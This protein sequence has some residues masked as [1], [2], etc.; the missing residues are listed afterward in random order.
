MTAN[1][2][3]VVRRGHSTRVGGG[4]SDPGSAYI[5]MTVL[6]AVEWLSRKTGTSD[7]KCGGGGGVDKATRIQI[8]RQGHGRLVVGT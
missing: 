8:A 4:D 7:S 3:V 6:V 2:V 5:T 1:V